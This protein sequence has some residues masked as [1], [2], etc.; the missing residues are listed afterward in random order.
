LVIAYPLEKKTAGKQKKIYLV[1]NTVTTETVSRGQK[2]G[3]DKKSV[4]MCG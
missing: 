2:A 1:T 4:L 3:L